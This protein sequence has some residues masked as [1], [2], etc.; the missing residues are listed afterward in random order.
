MARQTLPPGSYGTIKA[1]K[2]GAKT[3]EARCKYRD[4]NGVITR[5]SKR[6][7]TKP[8][9]ET[10]LRAH[11]ATIA[12]KSARGEIDRESRFRDVAELWLTQDIEHEIN[13]G[14]LSHGTLRTYRSVLNVRV[15]PRLGSLQLREVTVYAVDSLIKDTRDA[16]S[17]SMASTVRTIVS[18]VM[19]YA[20]RHGA[21][22]ANPVRSAQRIRAS[23]EEATE[24]V[25]MTVEQIEKM[26]AALKAFGDE[27]LVKQKGRR[28]GTRAV[29][30]TDL[31]ELA[32]GMLATGVRIG[33][34]LALTGESVIK[35]KKA[36]P[37][38]RVDGHIIRVPGEGLVRVPGRKGNKPGIDLPL[39]P[40]A[41]PMFNRR[42]LASGGGPLWACTAGTWLDPS[43]TANRIK[44][45]LVDSGYEWVTS[46]VWRHT[47]G[48]LLNEA[49]LEIGEIAEQ[50]GNTRA[51]AEKHYVGRATNS[52]AADA[53]QE[54]LG[55][56][57]GKVSGAG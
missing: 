12:T 31:P 23:R 57:A 8:A 34:L 16:K 6:G 43:N 29:V 7:P 51:V 15:L 20:V 42:K 53:L 17:R 27:K 5:P 44:A 19:G 49:G 3:W 32:L 54:V 18:G 10:A 9:A 14:V 30:W 4:L 22:D 11:L 55:K 40:L 38:V 45:A 1:T 47:V 21:I 35:D 28:L 25:A 2:V 26:L 48:T 39:P 56:S 33:E 36:R 41:V 37:A 13:A 24:V 50:L 52:K 46:H